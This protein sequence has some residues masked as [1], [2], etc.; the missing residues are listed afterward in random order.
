MHLKQNKLIKAEAK[1]KKV[2]KMLKKKK[3]EREK[4]GS[5]LFGAVAQ[6]S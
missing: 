5:G 3:R 2:I 4:H 1:K 6:T